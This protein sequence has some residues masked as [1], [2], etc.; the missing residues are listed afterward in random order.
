MK[1]PKA[2]PATPEEAAEMLAVQRTGAP[3]SPS[4]LNLEPESLIEH[5]E[6][7]V[8]RTTE[9]EHLDTLYSEPLP[10]GYVVI[11]TID[12]QRRTIYSL[13][14]PP[15]AEDLPRLCAVDMRVVLAEAWDRHH[16]RWPDGVTPELLDRLVQHPPVPRCHV[17]RTLWELALHHVAYG[18]SIQAANLIAKDLSRSAAEREAALAFVGDVQTTSGPLEAVRMGRLAHLIGVWDD[19]DPMRASTMFY[20]DDQT[21]L[22][23]IALF[24]R[25]MNQAHPNAARW[26]NETCFHSVEPPR[27]T[28]EAEHRLAVTVARAWAA[29]LLMAKSCAVELVA[30]PSPSSEL[31]QLAIGEAMHAAERIESLR[32]VSPPVT[33]AHALMH[34]AKRV[35]RKGSPRLMKILA[36]QFTHFGV[37]AQPPG[38]A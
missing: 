33:T 10:P 7:I 11:F 30:G 1:L 18:A 19:E 13:R 15:G 12:A 14:P 22:P 5:M 31:A 2:E 36:G 26:W 20:E 4:L 8:A 9:A 24:S 38:R 17:L 27:S 25:Y 35:L 6:D 16:T 3:R 28:E 29:T 23:W 21:V 34:W 37:R 32:L